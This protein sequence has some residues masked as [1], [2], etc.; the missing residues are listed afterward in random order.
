MGSTDEVILFDGVCNLCNASVNFIIDRDPDS[1][2]SFASLQSEKAV[3]LLRKSTVNPK[4]LDGIILIKKEKIFQNSSAVLLIAKGLSGLWP[5]MYLFI[6]VPSFIRDGVYKL[7]ARNRYRWFG[8]SDQCRMPTSD[9][10]A[11]FI[12]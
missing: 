1:R 8:K 4:A 5:M 11:R 7:I 10:Q 3:E 2:F 9:L 6:I 12:D